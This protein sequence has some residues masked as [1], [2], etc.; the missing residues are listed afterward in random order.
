MKPEDGM[1]EMSGAMAELAVHYWKLCLAFER[2]LAFVPATRLQSGEAMLRF[3]RRK[4]ETILDRHAMRIVT[5][6]GEPWSPALP[7][8]PI[9]PDDVDTPDAIVDATIEPTIMGPSAAIIAGKVLL[10]NA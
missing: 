1:D 10:R 6:D 8:S 4:L 7:A 2:E 3:A 5:F 9:N